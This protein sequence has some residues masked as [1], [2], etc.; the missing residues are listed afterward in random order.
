MCR[1]LKIGKPNLL[2]FVLECAEACEDWHDKHFTG[3]SVA[4][5]EVD[6]QWAYVHTHK[7]RMTPEQKAEHPDR[8]DC[9]LWADSLARCFNFSCADS[10]SMVSS[11]SA[12]TGLI[13]MILP[14][15]ASVIGP[16]REDGGRIN[17]S[18]P[19]K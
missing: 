6:E 11:Y 9:W 7:E 13:A 18:G 15:S 5:L 1:L 14:R 16:M 2:R 19:Q 4:R 3:L 12:A 8:G 10:R 17:W